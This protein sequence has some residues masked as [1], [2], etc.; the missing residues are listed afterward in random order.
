MHKQPR[1]KRIF[2]RD[3]HAKIEASKEEYIEYQ[4]MTRL[5]SLQQAGE[6]LFSAVSNFLQYKYDK[7]TSSH[8]ETLKM[9]KN[10]KDDE[11]LL[12]DAGRLHSFYYNSTLY[13]PVYE[14]ER[15]FKRVLERL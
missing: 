6:K 11:D 3:Y 7:K 8:N 12:L 15:I 9:V 14:A 1:W 4:A 2:K 10:N 5:L 13:M